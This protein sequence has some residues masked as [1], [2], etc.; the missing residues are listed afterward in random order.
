MEECGNY[1]IARSILL[2]L[3]VLLF[4]CRINAKDKNNCNSRKKNRATT[5]FSHTSTDHSRLTLS[6]QTQV[7]LVPYSVTGGPW[8]PRNI[9]GLQWNSSLKIKVLCPFQHPLQSYFRFFFI[10]NTLPSSNIIGLCFPFLC[11]TFSLAS[12]P[13]IQYSDASM[14]F[15]FLNLGFQRS[16]A[17]HVRGSGL[18]LRAG[19]LLPSPTRG[20]RLTF[21]HGV[22]LQ[23]VSLCWV[24]I[25]HHSW[26]IVS[27]IVCL[28][29][30][31]CVS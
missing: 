14:S 21:L 10:T 6:S 17:R 26:N 22:W 31:V 25:L 23:T 19:K 12:F 7:L 5:W 4:T 3:C 24:S 8:C 27:L 15:T 13:S 11:I 2:L 9:I 20:T 29:A 18:P 1:F 30:C 28:S 16:A